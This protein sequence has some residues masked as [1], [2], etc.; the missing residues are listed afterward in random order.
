[1]SFTRKRTSAAAITLLGFGSAPALAEPTIYQ[2]SGIV[3]EAE[4]LAFS[5]INGNPLFQFPEPSQL[6]I[7]FSGTFTVDNAGGFAQLDIGGSFSEPGA[8][9]TWDVATPNV[10]GGLEVLDFSGPVQFADAF[11][12]FD[13]QIAL[14]ASSGVG[15]F[16]FRDPG[17]V[18]TSPGQD[19]F[20]SGTITSVNVV[21][22]PATIALAGA[23]LFFSG[24]RRR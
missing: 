2:I 5:I 21:P 22:P 7:P 20:V 12:D 23:G 8:S 16:S 15:S 11:D 3:T 13:F 1:M 17:A 19:V 14:T 6:P 24:T 10:I 4:N 18:P 9:V